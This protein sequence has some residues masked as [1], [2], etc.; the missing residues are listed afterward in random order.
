MYI[1]FDIPPR[2]RPNKIVLELSFPEFLRLV[3]QMSLQNIEEAVITS[4]R[5]YGLGISEEEI[6]NACN[7]TMTDELVK[8]LKDIL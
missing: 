8:R 5:N 4:N 1:K 3:G 6:R 2:P 7:T